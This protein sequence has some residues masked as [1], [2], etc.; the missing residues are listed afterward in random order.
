MDAVKFLEIRKRMCSELAC[1][2]CPLGYEEDGFMLCKAF[3]EHEN[4]EEAVQIVEE[5][6]KNNPVK[7]RQSEF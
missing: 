3:T 6:A 4:F 7:T 2:E 5:W 1:Y